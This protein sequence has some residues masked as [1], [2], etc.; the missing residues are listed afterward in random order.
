MRKLENRHA[1]HILPFVRPRP[2]YQCEKAFWA[3]PGE[4]GAEG[5]RPPALPTVHVPDITIP[6][7]RY[8]D[9]T[10]LHPKRDKVVDTTTKKKP[11]KRARR[12][13]EQSENET[14]ESDSDN[15]AAFQDPRA[16]KE[17]KCQLSDAKVGTFAMLEVI[18]DEGNGI[19][20]MQVKS[21]KMTKKAEIRRDGG[22][23]RRDGGKAE[24]G[25]WFH[26]FLFR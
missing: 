9:P 25:S 20:L 1:T 26:F 8:S 17:W 18:Y 13:S 15:E 6:I 23:K 22:E 19:S 16:P 7:V 4:D 24:A 2:L 21:R 14:S 12:Q 11:K 3:L 5:I 10:R